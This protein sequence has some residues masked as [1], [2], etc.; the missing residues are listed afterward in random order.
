MPCRRLALR[1]SA[2][3]S[4]LP[5]SARKSAVAMIRPGS[6]TP[7]ARASSQISLGSRP[8]GLLVLLLVAVAGDLGRR[9]SA[10]E[11]VAASP[12]R[13]AMAAGPG[14]AGR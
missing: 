6:L 8:C 12:S 5:F 1:N 3:W 7:L 9:S 4:N 2:A 11:A 14:A 13:R 10:D